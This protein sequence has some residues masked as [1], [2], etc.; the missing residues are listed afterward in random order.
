MKA[1]GIMIVE[2]ESLVGLDLQNN[3]TDM[4]YRVTSVHAEAQLAIDSIVDE[5]PDLVL[6]DIKLRGE[7]DGIDAAREIQ[8]RFGIPVLFLTA[9]A[10]SKILARAREVGAYGYMIKPFANKELRAMVEVALCKHRTEVETQQL[11]N[12]IRQAQKYESLRLMAGGIAHRFNNS[13]HS[14]LGYLA[15]ALEDLP[16]GS[17]VLTSLESARKGAADAADLGAQLLACSGRGFYDTKEMNLTALL[18]QTLFPLEALMP[19]SV[20]L[21][22]ELMEDLPHVQVDPEQLEMVLVALVTNSVESLIDKPGTIS[23]HTSI[24]NCSQNDLAAIRTNQFLDAGMYVRLAVVD[25]GCGMEKEIAQKV[26]D[27]FF[28]TKFTGR[29]LG[30]AATLGIVQAHGGTVRVVSE[31]GQGT[32]VELFLPVD[33]S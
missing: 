29:G 30:L 32:T 7:M 2:D 15:F 10:D 9:F 18:K 3:L 12:R 33:Q 17:P 16:P 11:N 22:L 28:T 14:V 27:P 8:V 31:P 19:P 21:N 20:V 25:T 6:M 26:F 13:M 23:I 24:K 5:T 1:P 4:G